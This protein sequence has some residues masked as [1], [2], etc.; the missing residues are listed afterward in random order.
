MK[1]ISLFMASLAIM[2]IYA[3]SPGLYVPSKT[4]VKDP[5]VDIGPLT[6][7][8]QLYKN[9]CHKCH[10]LKKPNRY[11]AEQWVKILDKMQPKA[12]IDNEQRKLIYAYLING[13]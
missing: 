11:N 6:V 1:K 8:M 2:V 7:G 9:S 4:T 3:C 13:K 5:T 10:G 12:K